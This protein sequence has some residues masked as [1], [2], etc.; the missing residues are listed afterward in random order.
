M[1]FI[2]FRIYIDDNSRSHDR[3]QVLVLDI[4]NIIIAIKNI[5]NMS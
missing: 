3:R 2:A 5:N 4:I 1:L